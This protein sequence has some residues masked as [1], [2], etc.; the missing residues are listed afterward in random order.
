[1]SERYYAAACQTDSPCPSDR[2]EIAGRTKRM[3]ELIEQTVDGYEPFFDVRYFVFPEFAHAY[4][5]FRP[6][7]RSRCPTN[8]PTSTRV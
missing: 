2:T 4:G 6:T 3:C 8:T 5:N 7:W 1:M